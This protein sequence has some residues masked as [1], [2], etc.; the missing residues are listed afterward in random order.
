MYETEKERIAQEFIDRYYSWLAE[1]NGTELTDLEYGRKYGYGRHS[2]PFK[3]TQK[4]CM[5]FRTYI[6]SGRYIW[7][8]EDAGYDKPTIYGLHRAGFLSYIHSTSYRAR[9]L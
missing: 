7:A 5:Y 4:T 6:F 1:H 8:W 9:A 3:D 2:E